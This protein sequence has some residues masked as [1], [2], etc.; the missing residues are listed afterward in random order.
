MNA[1]EEKPKCT[2]CGAEM[3]VIRGPFRIKVDGKHLTA[4]GDCYHCKN[5]ECGSF[6]VNKELGSSVIE[7]GDW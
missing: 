5:K 4:F 1:E 2:V 6:S 7:A 3:E